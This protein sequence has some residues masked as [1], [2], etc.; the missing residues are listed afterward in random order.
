MADANLQHGLTTKP[1]SINLKRQGIVAKS[2]GVF[3]M[4]YQ[5]LTGKRIPNDLRLRFVDLLG[6]ATDVGY[7]FRKLKYGT[8][9]FCFCKFAIAI[10]GNT[11]RAFTLVAALGTHEGGLDRLQKQ[12]AK[13]FDE[14]TVDPRL[15]RDI[16]GLLGHGR[17]TSS[18]YE[19]KTEYPVAN[20]ATDIMKVMLK[21][22]QRFPI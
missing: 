7:E 21:R 4:F 17:A 6:Y 2:N 8:R 20:N 3:P 9:P 12:L 22:H 11:N 16:F 19:R 5:Q 18:F 10:N 15:V 14:V 1:I 13:T